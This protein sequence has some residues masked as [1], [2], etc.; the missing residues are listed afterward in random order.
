MTPH[1]NWFAAAL[2]LLFAGAPARAQDPLKPLEK[3]AEKP[4]D[5]PAA[6]P[7]E[8]LTAWPKPADKDVV[9]TDIE[10]VVKAH[11]PEMAIQGRDALIAGGASV[12]PFVLERYGREKNEA[13]AERLHE[14]LIA[15]TGPEQTVL[16]SKEFE[17]KLLP[18]R[19]FTLHRTA[20]FPDKGIVAAAEKAWA[21][22][23]KQ[24]EKADPEERYSAALCAASAGSVAGFEALFEACKTKRWDAEKKE[25]R[26]ALE[27]VRGKPA[28]D[29]ALAKLQ[30]ADRKTKVAVLRMLAGC[31]EKEQAGKLRGFLDDEDN[32]IRVA[33]INALLGMVDDKPP[34]ENLAAFEAIEMAKEWKG[35]KL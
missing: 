9:L 29:L 27:G 28:T 15:T 35:R 2:V 32:A 19:V 11:V 7:V 25:I 1:R 17:N 13:V 26:T 30:D 34:I 6:A 12:V 4:A 3:P 33:A 10:R 20:A 21:R 24:G 18:V 8:K 14:V 22:V 16:L 23:A 5:K 31:G